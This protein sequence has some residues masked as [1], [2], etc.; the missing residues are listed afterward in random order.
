MDHAH[1]VHGDECFGERGSQRE[2]LVFGQRPL[3][4]HVLGQRGPLDVLGGHPRA[5]CVGVGVDDTRGPETADPAHVRHLMAEPVA[6]GGLLGEPRGDEF[7]RDASTTA[8]PAQVDGAHRTR[9][10]AAHQ[11]VV[12]NVTRIVV[13]QRP[14]STPRELDV[15]RSVADGSR[16]RRRFDLGPRVS[17][18][19]CRWVK[20]L[21]RFG[22]VREVIGHRSRDD[23]PRSWRGVTVDARTTSGGFRSWRDGT[24]ETV[25][26]TGV[27]VRSAPRRIG[28]GGRCL[29]RTGR[30]SRARH[31]TAAATTVAY[32][33]DR[34]VYDPLATGTSAS[35]RGRSP[36][37]R[38]SS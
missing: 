2:H 23:E 4:L 27:G 29:T 10:Q 33:H 38:T 22:V 35:R 34:P 25:A 12:P 19:R 31:G 32:A 3:V 8:R 24:G 21:V 36:T 14:H 1:L 26:P 9:T 28:R 18:A 17:A 30:R 6:E 11:R 20:C 15:R 37:T 16:P 7:H 13:R 5:G